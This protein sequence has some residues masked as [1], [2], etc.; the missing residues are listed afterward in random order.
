MLRRIFTRGHERSGGHPNKANLT[1]FFVCKLSPLLDAA[2]RNDEPELKASYQRVVAALRELACPELLELCQ[3]IGPNLTTT[4]RSLAAL[5]V[6]YP[7][8]CAVNKKWL[9]PNG[10]FVAPAY[11]RFP[12]AGFFNLVIDIFEVDRDGTST[13]STGD[14]FQVFSG[15]CLSPWPQNERGFCLKGDS[16]IYLNSSAIH[17]SAEHAKG[18][19]TNGRDGVRIAKGPSILNDPELRRWFASNFA[20]GDTA[21]IR[22]SIE[23]DV[24]VHETG[25]KFKECHG[26]KS[27]LSCLW[28]T[29]SK[30]NFVHISFN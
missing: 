27:R 19:A 21:S 24:S 9:H 2:I 17:A 23:H 12:P 16:C 1:D 30:M 4:S 14:M 5:D 29:M 3:V 7:A 8:T 11:M 15:R 18:L 28:T 13:L 26:L 6:L 20:E 25:H 10:L 22:R